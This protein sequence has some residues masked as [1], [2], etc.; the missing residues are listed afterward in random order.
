MLDVYFKVGTP[1]LS[2][3]P[4]LPSVPMSP[5]SLF[6]LLCGRGSGG[7]YGGRSRHVCNSWHCVASTAPSAPYVASVGSFATSRPTNGFSERTRKIWWGGPT[8]GLENLYVT[9]EQQ[10]N[11]AQNFPGARC[12]RRLHPATMPATNCTCP[13]FVP[14]SRRRARLCAAPAGADERDRSS[15]RTS[16]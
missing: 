15:C 13:Q 2:R 9:T 14:L 12:A 16:L 8:T 10:T 4:S 11:T 6:C 3:V 5:F 7:P 1:S